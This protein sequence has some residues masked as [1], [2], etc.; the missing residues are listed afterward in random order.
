MTPSAPFA[1]SRASA[2]ARSGWLFALLVP[3]AVGA[4]DWPQFLGPSRNGA[5]D[6][7]GLQI[8]WKGESPPL[9]WEKEVGEGYSA[10]AVA[11]AR[12]VVFHRLGDKEVLDCLEASSGKPIWRFEHPTRYVDDY[13]AGHGPRATPA[14]ADGKVYAFGAEGA[15]H[16]LDLESGKALWTVKTEERFE[17]P[18]GFFGA[19][20]SPLVEDGKVL[21]NLGGAGGAGIAAFDAK[22]GALVWKATDH[23][24][25]YS[26]PVTAAIRGE[27]HAFF[28]TRKGLVD[29]DPTNG[30]VR[31][32][33]F[34]RAR[35]AASVNAA[36]PLVIGERVFIS[37]SYGTGAA[38]L[39]IGG[40][41]PK[42]VW[43]G[44]ESLSSHYATSIHRDGLL[45][46]FHGRQ[47]GPGPL[48]RAVDLETG[49]PR[50]SAERMGAGSL[51]LS[52]AE[53]LIQLESGELVVAPAAGNGFKPRLRAHLLDPT[54]RAFAALAGGR[55]YARNDERLRCFDLRVKKD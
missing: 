17:I 23:E 7:K 47:E 11:G 28:F 46:G 22:D 2:A 44:D 36:T 50:W 13:G 9:L 41:E 24:A 53:L 51:I 14:I 39:D 55:Y 27:R 4:A 49:K 21:L 26:S 35:I 29:L 18:K 30:R 5:S 48:L 43:S 42:T 34:W 52:G 25:G 54:V 19:A 10:P 40:K 45:F 37:A 3:A 33:F 38:L 15:L 12:L 8:G 20:G 1:A 32:D 31:F 6:D 16:C